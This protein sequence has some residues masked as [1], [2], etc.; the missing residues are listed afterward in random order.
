[1][2]SMTWRLLGSYIIAHTHLTTE[3]IA[4]IKV[5]SK[6]STMDPN[7]GDSRAYILTTYNIIVAVT[8]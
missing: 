8:V 4:E 3:Y 6:I 7:I 1:M 2:I 5:E